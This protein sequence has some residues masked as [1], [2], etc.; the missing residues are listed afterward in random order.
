MLL[1]AR[2]KGRL[3]TA[4]GQY[5]PQLVLLV[6]LANLADVDFLIGLGTVGNANVLH[7]GFTHSLAAAVFVALAVSCVWRI[8]GSFWRSAILYFSAYS[9]HLLIDLCTGTT[10]GWNATASGIPL[11]W[12]W[13]KEFRSPLVLVVGVSHKD[14]PALFSMKNAW[15]SFYELL[16]FGAITVAL[17][18]LRVR[19]EERRTISRNRETASRAVSNSHPN[20]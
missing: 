17:L 16:T 18:A 15:S 19:H 3:A 5:L 10:L 11:F 9:S 6:L 2:L 14:L 4:C 20:R 12:P 8:A 13:A 7:H 1:T